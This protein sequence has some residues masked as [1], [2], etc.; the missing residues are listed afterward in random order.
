MAVNDEHK[1][2]VFK[3]LFGNP[4]NREWTLALYNAVNGSNYDNADEI[5]YNTIEDAVYLGM[6]NDVSFIIVNELHLW[7]HQSTYNPNMPMRFLLYAA[8]LYEKYIAGS[9]YYPYSSVLQPAPRPKCVC[10]Y[11][12][13]GNQPEHTIL[14]LSEAFGGEGD[15]E[16]LVTMLNINY[17]KNRELMAVCEPLSEYAWLVEAIR[18]NQ[19][20]MRN[21]EAAI[22]A[23]IDEMPDEFV[24]KRFLLQN[25]AEVKGMF[26]T[27]YDQEK[28]LSQERR[29]VEYRVATDMLIDNYPLSAIA[30]ISKLSEDAIRILANSLG[31]SIA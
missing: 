14:R 20:I 17:G 30:K 23:A 8:K 4:A 18:R 31:I 24:I 15:I 11:N 6:R 1:D 27:E 25:K 13:T 28:V 22:D 29:E 7:E 16:V 19:K 26:L 10:F 9:D 2:R 5:Q 3:Y 21:L 12:G